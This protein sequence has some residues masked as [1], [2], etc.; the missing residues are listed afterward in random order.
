MTRPDATE[1]TEQSRTET[2]LYEWSAGGMTMTLPRSWQLPHFSGPL[3]DEA[4]TG[5]H[6]WS[7]DGKRV[8]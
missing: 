6:G 7:G 2:N 3:V 1:L 5:G 8:K 4:N